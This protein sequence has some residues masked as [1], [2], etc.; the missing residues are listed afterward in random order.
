M[1]D[2]ELINLLNDIMQGIQNGTEHA[3]HVQNVCDNEAMR[4]AERYG[5]EY[6]NDGWRGYK[7]YGWIH[8][9]TKE[10]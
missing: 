1:N 3:N 9:P 7:R 8:I 10:D 6:P 5:I 2:N 4:I